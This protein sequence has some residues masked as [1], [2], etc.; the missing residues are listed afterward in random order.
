M[1]MIIHRT[2]RD[3]ERCRKKYGEAWKQY[4]KEV[5]YLFIPVSLGLGLSDISAENHTDATTVSYLRH[6][7]TILDSVQGN[8]Q[9]A[10]LEGPWFS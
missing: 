6:I 8:K 4:E 2:Y 7:D 10:R 9:G 5:P 1:G 3:A